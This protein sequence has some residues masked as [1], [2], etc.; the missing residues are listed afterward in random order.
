M[1][2]VETVRFTTV[3]SGF[4]TEA[5]RQPN[6]FNGKLFF[7]ND[8]IFEIASEWNLGGSDERRIR[9]FDA[10]NLRFW[11]TRVIAGTE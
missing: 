7:I 2:A 3:G 6:K 9:T 11:S 10:I 1:D 4:A 8:V 5:M